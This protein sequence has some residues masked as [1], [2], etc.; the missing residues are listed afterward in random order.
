MASNAIGSG[1]GYVYVCK[2]KLPWKCNTE[3]MHAVRLWEMHN[4]KGAKYVLGK[5]N[6]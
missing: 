1:V 5:N 6:P 4:V 2:S 3:S